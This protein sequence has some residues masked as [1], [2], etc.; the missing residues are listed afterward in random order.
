MPMYFPEWTK[1]DVEGDTTATLAM[2]GEDHSAKVHFAFYAVVECQWSVY[3]YNSSDPEDYPEPPS[4][5]KVEP[6]EEIDIYINGDEAYPGD[7]LYDLALRWALDEIENANYEPE[8]NH[9]A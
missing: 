2:C 9:D 4:L 5:K 3:N 8:F 1:T 6:V 7:I